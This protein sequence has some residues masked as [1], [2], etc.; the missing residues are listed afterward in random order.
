MDQYRFLGLQANLVW[1][2]HGPIQVLGLQANLVWSPHGPIQVLGLQPL[3]GPLPRAHITTSTDRDC[4]KSGSKRDLGPNL[5]GRDL[6]RHFVGL[7]GRECGC[8]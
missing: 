2:P 4:A 7:V 3:V 6:G 1:S 8:I 5:K